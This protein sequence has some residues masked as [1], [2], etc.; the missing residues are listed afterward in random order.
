MPSAV[1]PFVMFNGQAEEAIN[2]YLSVFKGSRLE[3]IVRYGVDGMGAE[4]SVMHS[5]LFIAGQKMIFIDSA[6]THKFAFSP[7][8]SFFVNCESIAEVDEYHKALSAHGKVLMPLDSYEF[9]AR[10][11][12]VIDR[13]GLSWQLGH[14]T[15]AKPPEPG[16]SIL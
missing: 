14:K 12:W 10:Y 1:T 6:I 8:Q 15:V 11:T 16:K 5:T 4:G 7:S 9:S 13:F 3:S 2:F